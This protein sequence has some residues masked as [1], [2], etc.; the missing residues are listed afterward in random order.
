[1]DT[2]H[3]PAGS[4]HGAAT[5]PPADASGGGHAQHRGQLPVIN[6][7]HASADQ[8][9]GEGAAHHDTQWP[10]GHGLHFENQ[11]LTP[12][13]RY[14]AINKW[15]MSV[16]L[17]KCVGCN[18]CVIACQAENNIPIV[19]KDQVARGREMHWMRI[20]AYF[21]EDNTDPDAEHADFKFQPV[22]CMHCENAPCETV[23]PVA[24]TSH[25]DEGLNDMAYNRCIGTRYCGNNCPYKVRRF[26]YLN[27]SEAVTFLKYPNEGLYTER[28][29]SIRGLGMN[30]EVTVRSRGVMEK[31]TYCVQRIQNTK[32]R[33][34]NEKRA[35]GPNEITTA[36]QDACPT[37]AI[38]FGNLADHASDVRRNHL[39]VRAYQLL[40]QLNNL[41]RTRYLARVRNPH[42]KLARTAPP[43]AHG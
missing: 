33:A 3:T 35:I 41:P 26:N 13:P 34:R 23:C 24:A 30:P 28:E 17:T 6:I 39:S 22:A 38:V 4:G 12:G 25:S 40:D 14:S 15:G 18:A 5:P 29:K 31:C 1:L 11:S 9:Q 21:V 36:C 37:G 16:D 8:E 19:G 32:I 20:D 42:P 2:E 27:F 7:S 43:Q 10:G